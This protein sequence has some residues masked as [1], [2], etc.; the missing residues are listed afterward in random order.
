MMDE[1][2]RCVSP[3]LLADSNWKTSL[4]LIHPLGDFCRPGDSHFHFIMEYKNMCEYTI[5]MLVNFAESARKIATRSVAPALWHVK[6][7]IPNSTNTP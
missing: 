3:A 5:I 7:N 4:G 6:I 2:V 1:S